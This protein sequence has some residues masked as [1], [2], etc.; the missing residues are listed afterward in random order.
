MTPETESNGTVS[1]P[2][3]WS[4]L[5]SSTEA[6]K[7]QLRLSHPDYEKLLGYCAFALVAL[8]ERAPRTKPSLAEKVLSALSQGESVEAVRAAIEP[9]AGAP[10]G[11]AVVD[12]IQT[13]L[14]QTSSTA[15]KKVAR[16]AALAKHAASPKADARASVRQKWIEWESKP[17]LYDGPTDFAQE[18]R[19]QFPVLSN[20]EVI[21]RWVRRWKA[22]DGAT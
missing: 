4:N 12:A 7:A 22:G 13:L 9:L 15:R 8:E 1:M 21:M 3:Y 18:M 17:H 16:Q 19:K 10:A 6:R 20:E 2:P 14:E 11:L 5:L